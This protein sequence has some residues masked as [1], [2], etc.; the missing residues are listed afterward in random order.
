MHVNETPARNETPERTPT[1]E[2]TDARRRE[3][4]RRFGRA[5]TYAVPATLTL[6]AVRRAA[7]AS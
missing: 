7:A 3:M 1:A 6:M 2:T 5:A 4:L